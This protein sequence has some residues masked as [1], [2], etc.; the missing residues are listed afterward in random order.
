M[1]DFFDDSYDDGTCKIIRFLGKRGVRARNFVVDFRFINKIDMS[2]NL[3]F[4][5]FKADST[6]DF[7]ESE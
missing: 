6:F 7:V 5:F 2:W 1:E 3:F 4:N